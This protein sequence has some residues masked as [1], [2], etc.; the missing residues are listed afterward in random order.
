MKRYISLILVCVLFLCV[1]CS[2]QPTEP[3]ISTVQSRESVTT[4]TTVSTTFAAN[5]T[6]TTVTDSSTFTLGRNTTRRY[7]EL[8]KK[9]VE[10]PVN[11]KFYARTELKIWKSESAYDSGESPIAVC[12]VGTEVFV[13]SRT[14]DGW[15]KI[16]HDS[17]EA[18]VWFKN[19]TSRRLWPA[20]KTTVVADSKTKS[21]KGYS[22]VTTGGMTFVD[23]VLVANKTYSLP[24]NY[25]PGG[26]TKECN[27]A[28]RNMKNAAAKEGFSLYDSS[29]FRSYETQQAIYNRYVAKDGKANADR[30]SARPGYSEHQTG[31]AIDLNG[32]SDSFG[33]TKEG[34]WVA[35]HCHEFGFILRYPQGKEA[36]TGYM[37]EPWHIRYVGL[38]VAKK[39]HE[40]GL[41][42]EEFYGITSAYAD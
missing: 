28:F 13:I 33:E 42:L 22:I 34:K 41:C 29:D 23:G 18:F 27:S 31:L 37:Y 19:L 36:E 12:P 9:V 40:S 14:S 17:G 39:I 20:Q 24:A 32:V 7:P 8:T 5:R 25:N 3:E 35:E 2:K 6:Q 10:T 15:A 4:K 21:S 26:L 16:K 1:A 30:Y 38:E 11:K